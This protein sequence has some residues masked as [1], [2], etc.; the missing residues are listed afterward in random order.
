MGKSE[1]P[2]EDV[3][4]A[5]QPK[6][7]KDYFQFEEDGVVK[8]EIKES[9]PEEKLDEAEAQK[10]EKSE[11][12]EQEVKPEN[13]ETDIPDRFVVKN[14]DGSID[15]AETAKKAGKS[16]SE[17]EKMRGRQGQMMGDL[18]KEREEWQ[19]KYESLYEAKA[20]QEPVEE[21]TEEKVIEWLEKNPKK[22][23]EGITSEVIS[24]LTK[25]NVEKE[26]QRAKD[27][28]IFQNE[29]L[30]YLDKHPEIEKHYESMTKIFSG[31]TEEEKFRLMRDVPTMMDSL[32]KDVR[33]KELEE[34]S[35]KAA[36][37]PKPPK[38]EGKA[39][40]GGGKNN[41]DKLKAAGLS[42]EEIAF[43]KG[44]GMSDDEILNTI[45]RR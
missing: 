14:E 12:P 8:E 6:E 26:Q 20:S 1:D 5:E 2:K 37:D 11:K 34:V 30:M 45:K 16:W 29:V 19:R 27:T 4:K 28:Q 31:K 44:F 41:V 39:V 7:P 32:L 25:R 13:A 23:V 38:D 36:Y 33:I 43:G 21:L 3:T 42:D 22:L 18:K 9:K 10:E 24:N 35:K 40:A 15:W 17:G